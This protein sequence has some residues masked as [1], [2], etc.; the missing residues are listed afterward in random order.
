MV[1]SLKDC[2]ALLVKMAGKHLEEDFRDA[3]MPLFKTKVTE[4]INIANNFAQKP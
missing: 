4:L 1:I 3:K 2:N